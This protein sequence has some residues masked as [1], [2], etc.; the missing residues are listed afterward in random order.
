MKII[1][2][3]AILMVAP[4]ITNAQD[5]DTKKYELGINLYNITDYGKLGMFWYE[6]LDQNFEQRF[7]TGV[8]FKRNWSKSALR[9]SVDYMYR[10]KDSEEYR[11]H[12]NNT[13]INEGIV[14]KTL[15][16]LRFENRT[17]YERQFL[18]SRKVK[19]FATIDLVAGVDLYSATYKASEI[20]PNDED[21]L[22][23]S[24]V[25][26]VG[27]SIALGF[28]YQISNRLSASVETNVE[29]VGNY[30][31]I[32]NN[33]QNQGFYLILNPV[34]LLSINYHF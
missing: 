11:T 32:Q 27:G 3:I 17:G 14:D 26:R 7:V 25:L 29:Y 30:L 2:L 18:V 34:R 33:T 12:N 1:S 23:K 31:V 22:Y 20:I 21:K 28:K 19:P 10:S 16:F 6:D 8:M 5:T 24:T 9:V 13:F 15:S 4:F